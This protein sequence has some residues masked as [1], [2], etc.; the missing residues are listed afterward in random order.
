MS[1]RSR[2]ANGRY[3]ATDPTTDPTGGGGDDNRGPDLSANTETEPV[4]DQGAVPDAGDLAGQGGEGAGTDSESS[5]DPS[6][7]GSGSDDEVE[8]TDKDQP[9]PAQAFRKAAEDGIRDWLATISSKDE[10]GSV[11]QALRSAGIHIPGIEEEDPSLLAT[12]SQSSPFLLQHNL[13]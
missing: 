6:Q 13:R 7:D 8:H 9:D 11:V 10:M 4:A 2:A 12:T 1:T 3:I 5:T